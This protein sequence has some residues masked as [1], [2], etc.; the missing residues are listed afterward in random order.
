MRIIWGILFLLGCSPEYGVSPSGGIPKFFVDTATYETTTPTIPT[1]ELTPPD[2]VDFAPRILVEPLDYDFG[3]LLINC[4]DEYDLTI[5]S[6]GTAPLIIDDLM[7]TGGTLEATAKLVEKVGGAVHEIVTIID[8][9]FLNGRDKIA[10]YPF[11]A[12][13]QY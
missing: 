3:E 10:Q 5:S 11:Y 4:H 7:A 13:L 1:R 2:D 8:L 6:V 12:C 9:T